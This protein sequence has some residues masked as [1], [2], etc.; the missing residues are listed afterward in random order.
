[1]GQSRENLRFSDQVYIMNYRDRNIPDEV[2]KS[3]AVEFM[4]RTRMLPYILTVISVPS[5]IKATAETFEK[6]YKIGGNQVKIEAA[7]IGGSS[8]D[9]KKINFATEI[10]GLETSDII[11]RYGIKTYGDLENFVSGFAYPPGDLDWIIITDQ[12]LDSTEEEIFTA[13]EIFAKKLKRKASKIPK[14]LSKINPRFSHDFGVE[15]IT[16]K[17]NL[18]LLTFNSKNKVV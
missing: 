9:S 1:M 10:S 7:L 11:K 4:V 8:V 6:E 12:K 16:D 14:A 5:I 3:D 13:K 15:S 17:T 2:S 18:S